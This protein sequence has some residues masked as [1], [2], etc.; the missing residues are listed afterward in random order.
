MAIR[1]PYNVYPNCEEATRLSKAEAQGFFPWTSGPLALIGLIILFVASGMESPF[2]LFLL[3]P[4]IAALI[5]AFVYR[6]K[7]YRKRINQAL[8][9]CHMKEISSS[10]N[11]TRYR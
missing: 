11:N 1:I 4:L 6:P 5:Y 2:Y 10:A 8:Y 7:K 9:H 3:I